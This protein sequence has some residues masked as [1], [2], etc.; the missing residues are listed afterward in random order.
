M[1]WPDRFRAIG[2][3]ELVYVTDK[4]SKVVIRALQT[5]WEEGTTKVV[6]TVFEKGVIST[7][8]ATK[9]GLAQIVTISNE[10]QEQGGGN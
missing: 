4:V 1:A 9:E 8:T 2:G 7:I 6:V 10:V 3:T 5:L